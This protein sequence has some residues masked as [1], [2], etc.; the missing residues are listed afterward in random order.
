LLVYARTP[1]VQATS[2]KHRGMQDSLGQQRDSGYLCRYLLGSG[3]TGLR[4]PLFFV[5]FLELG[6][7]FKSHLLKPSAMRKPSK[8]LLA[9]GPRLFPLQITYMGSAVQGRTL[10]ACSSLKIGCAVTS[11]KA[12]VGGLWSKEEGVAKLYLVCTWLGPKGGTRS[13]VELY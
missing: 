9:S 12:N 10:L 13:A 6:A 8:L 7:P 3:L 5:T 4:A 2:G 11:E 1:Y